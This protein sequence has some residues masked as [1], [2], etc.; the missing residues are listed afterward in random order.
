M[1]QCTFDLY[2]CSPRLRGVRGEFLRA[3][4][5]PMSAALLGFIVMIP[6][7]VWAAVLGALL[8][9]ALAWWGWS[10][11]DRADRAGAAL[12]GAAGIVIEWISRPLAK[13][14]E[15]RPLL[16][17]HLFRLDLDICHARLGAPHS[18]LAPKLTPT[19]FLARASG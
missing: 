6:D 7:G 19:P 15:I 13:H 16:R 14:V 5:H 17:A 11:Q 1:E 18:C 10:V 8:A 12:L 3:L 9:A 4:T 2:V